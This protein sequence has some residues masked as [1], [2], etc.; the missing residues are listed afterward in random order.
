MCHETMLLEQLKGHLMA[1]IQPQMVIPQ[2]D[3]S[4]TVIIQIQTIGLLDHQ[5]CKLE[6]I[7]IAIHIHNNQMEI[8]QMLIQI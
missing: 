6:I 4:K 7:I 5:V 1:L 3:N 2:I 8:L